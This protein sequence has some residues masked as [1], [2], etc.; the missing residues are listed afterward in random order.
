[1]VSAVSTKYPVIRNHRLTDEVF[2]LVIKAPGIAGTAIPGQFLMVKCRDCY[3]PLLSRPFSV[4]GVASDEIFILNRIQGKGTTMISTFKAGEEINIL[5]PLGQGFAWIEDGGPFWLVAGGLGIAPL[6]FLAQKMA[7]ANADF[8][9]LWGAR[10]MEKFSFSFILEELRSYIE[11]Y[12]D[13]GSFGTKSTVCDGLASALA[14]ASPSSLPRT[15]FSCGPLPMLKSV[16]RTAQKHGVACQVSVEERMACGIG[17][18]LGCAIEGTD[19]IYHRVCK[20]GPVFSSE[21]IKI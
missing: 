3:D 10:D 14:E 8:R 6:G 16:V 15:I 4:H 21:A 9:L 13:D 19:G 2:E 17:A 5:G 11:F 1:M 18:C 12:T 20:D 7:I